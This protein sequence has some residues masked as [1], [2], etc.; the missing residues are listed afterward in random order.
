V[1]YIITENYAKMPHLAG[2]F[3]VKNRNIKKR[4]IRNKQ[5]SVKNKQTQKKKSQIQKAAVPTYVVEGNQG[6]TI[7]K[8]NGQSISGQG[9]IEE[10]TK[11]NIKKI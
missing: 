7:R 4:I 6:T 1:L 11:G 2:H 10:T 9:S 8:A 3:K 5:R